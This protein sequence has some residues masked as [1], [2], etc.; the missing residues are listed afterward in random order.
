V[1]HSLD[2]GE[3]V[4]LIRVRL[5]RVIHKDGVAVFSGLFL[6][7]ERNRVPEAAVR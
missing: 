4:P 3:E 6:Q 5:E 7:R 1:D 2:V